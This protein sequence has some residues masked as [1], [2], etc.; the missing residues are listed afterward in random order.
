DKEQFSNE[1]RDLKNVVVL[2][3]PFDG[4]KRPVWCF[5]KLFLRHQKSFLK[6]QNSDWILIREK[7]Y[8]CIQNYE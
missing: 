6:D 1:K 7:Y 4:I 8:L 3:L 2:S 5:K